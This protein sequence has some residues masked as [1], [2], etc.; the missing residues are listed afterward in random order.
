MIAGLRRRAGEWLFAPQPIERL[1]L[2]RILA[3]LAIL[4]FL[5]SRIGH[6]DAWLSTSAFHPPALIDDWRQPASLPPLQ[7]WAAWSVA[8][9]LALAGLAV[10]V[11]FAT[12]WATA[13]FAVLMIYTSLADRL[14]A[15]TVSKL[16]SVI[17]VALAFMPCGARYSVDAWRKRRRVRGWVAPELCSGGNVRFFQI[18]APVF[19]FSSG[20]CK[21]TGDWLTNPHVL[22]THLHDSYQTPVSWLAANTVP[23]FAWTVLQASVLAFEVGAPL[24]FGVRRLRPFALA[25]GIAMHAMIGLMF[26]PVAWFAL[27]MIAILV[28][29]Y[30]PATWLPRVCAW[31]SR[32]R[33]SPTSRP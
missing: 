26:G 16:G 27:L 22:F 6:A 12:R 3:P 7:P 25:Y 19:Y 4:G 24:W 20:I 15:F 14:E 28:A 13:V 33:P 29:S 10:C 1:E 11:G 23:A 2:V 8:I 9:G 30:A 31:I 18:L 32:A 21:A 5:S 17:A